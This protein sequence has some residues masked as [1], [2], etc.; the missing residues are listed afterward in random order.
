M[1]VWGQFIRN[2]FSSFAP[3]SSIASRSPSSKSLRHPGVRLLEIGEK[4]APLAKSS[5]PKKSLSIFQNPMCP[6]QLLGRSS[7]RAPSKTLANSNTSTTGYSVTADS[8]WAPGSPKRL[9][10]IAQMVR[11]L[12]IDDAILQMT[13]NKK[14][15]A[16]RLLATLIRVRARAKALNAPCD[17][18]VLCKNFLIFMIIHSFFDRGTWKNHP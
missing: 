10:F 7:S 12:S 5:P 13:F 4:L 2:G 8:G 17:R 1:P 9:N 15:A 11:G 16:R 6:Q 18:M 3:R 14:R